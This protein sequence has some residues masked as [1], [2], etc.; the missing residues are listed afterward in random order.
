MS[1]FALDQMGCVFTTE[2]GTVT[3]IPTVLDMAIGKSAVRLKPHSAG[4][5]IVA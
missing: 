1:N 4:R 2:T 5:A 3:P